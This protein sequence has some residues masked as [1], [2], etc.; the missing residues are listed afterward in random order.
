MIEVF[1]NDC[2]FFLNI[3][4]IFVKNAKNVIRRVKTKSVSNT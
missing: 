1:N 2:P 3:L 4:D